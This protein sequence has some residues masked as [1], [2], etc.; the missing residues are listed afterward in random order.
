QH[1]PRMEVPHEPG[2]TEASNR[3]RS[4]R[5][6]E[7]IAGCLVAHPSRR[8]NIVDEVAPGAYLRAHVEKLRQNSEDKMWLPQANMGRAR[9]RALRCVLDA[10]RRKFCHQDQYGPK[11]R[12]APQ[13][14]VWS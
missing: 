5:A 12:Q 8:L 3:E 1:K 9:S 11:E 14:K 7:H 2:R 6:S 10:Q 4:Q 13:H